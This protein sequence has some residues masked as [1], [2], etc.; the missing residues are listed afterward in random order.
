[1]RCNPNMSKKIVFYGSFSGNM[2]KSLNSKCPEGFET[3]QV[4]AGGDLS[5]LASADY[6]V[7]RGGAVDSRRHGR[8][9]PPQVDSEVGCRL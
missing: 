5:A 6:M 9:S 3:C 4:P 1:M 8:R 7:N 2:L